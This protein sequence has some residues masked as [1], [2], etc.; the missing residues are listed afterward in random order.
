[1]LTGSW[2]D[3]ATYSV[4]VGAGAAGAVGLSP[5]SIVVAALLLSLVRTKVLDERANE[6]A[7]EWRDAG[8][9]RGPGAAQALVFAASFCSHLLFGGIAF[10]VGAGIA[11]LVWWSRF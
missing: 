2:R 11:R 1:M 6:V 8:R 10:V 7:E 9:W 3:V 5:W 4:V